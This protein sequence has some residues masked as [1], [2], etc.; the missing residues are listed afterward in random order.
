[1]SL[2]NLSLTME[3]RQEDTEL[4][5]SANSGLMLELLVDAM[6][7]IEI[8]VACNLARTYLMKLLLLNRFQDNQ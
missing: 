5:Y 2:S 4:T 6:D 1:M 7:Y 3:C 8:L